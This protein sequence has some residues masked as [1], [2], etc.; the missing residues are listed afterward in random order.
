M[1]DQVAQD[2]STP[3]E[4]TEEP[5]PRWGVSLYMQWD[6]KD[7]QAAVDQFIEAIN[8]YGLRSFAYTVKDRHVEGDRYF[9]E[10]SVTYTDEQYEQKMDPENVIRD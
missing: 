2:P 6:G 1:T 5:D 3:D 7:P 4:A 10:D 8:A 9:V